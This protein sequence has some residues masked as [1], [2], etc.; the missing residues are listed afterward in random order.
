[1]LMLPF[2]HL[3]GQTGGIE[4]VKAETNRQHSSSTIDLPDGIEEGDLLILVTMANNV[5]VWWGGYVQYPGAPSSISPSGWSNATP[6]NSNGETWFSRDYSSQPSSA[7]FKDDVTRYKSRRWRTQ[8][9]YKIAEASD[10]GGTV[11]VINPSWARGG[12]STVFVFRNPFDVTRNDFTTGG[13]YNDNENTNSDLEGISLSDLS[14][15]S[16]VENA[17]GPTIVYMVNPVW[18][19][20]DESDPDFPYP[21][22]ISGFQFAPEEVPSDDFPNARFSAY[23]ISKK[24]YTY[25]LDKNPLFVGYMGIGL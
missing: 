24:T 2:I 17:S 18:G 19:V 6:S 10:I 1:M 23:G 14:W 25:S 9:F 21:T 5:N 12:Y 15:L 4:L 16:D 20:A 22:K 11:D 3:V 7:I 13:T 8:A